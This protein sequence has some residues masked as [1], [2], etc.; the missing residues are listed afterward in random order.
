MHYCHVAGGGQISFLIL[1]STGGPI[2]TAYSKAGKDF[3][4]RHKLKAI[5]ILSIIATVRSQV[6]C[7][8]R[9]K[10]ICGLKCL[11]TQNYQNATSLKV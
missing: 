9:A 7:Q 6:L 4:G 10:I 5:K 2:A 1:R 3:L 8:L 11:Q